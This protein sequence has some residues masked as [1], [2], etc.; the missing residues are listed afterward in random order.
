MVDFGV[1]CD[2]L[3]V[4]IGVGVQMRICK[5]GKVEMKIDESGVEDCETLLTKEEKKEGKAGKG[6][7]RR[8]LYNTRVDGLKGM[9][10]DMCGLMCC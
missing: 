10:N 2:G 4:G 8:G 3:S 5:N 7:R 1:V 6:M 9:Y